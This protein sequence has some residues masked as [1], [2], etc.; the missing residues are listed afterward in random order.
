MAG[1]R[2]VLIHL[3][4]EVDDREVV[5]HLKDDLWIIEKF[6]EVVKGLLNKR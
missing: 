3:Y 6:L 1:F 2:N 5:K 4:H